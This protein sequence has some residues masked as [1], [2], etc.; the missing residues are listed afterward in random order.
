MASSSFFR[1]VSFDCGNHYTG[2]VV[3]DVRPG[4]FF[5]IVHMKLIVDTSKNKEELF[6]GIEAEIDPFV[7]YIQNKS[8]VILEQCLFPNWTLQRVQDKIKDHYTALGVRCKT[9]MPTQKSSGGLPGQKNIS[10]G[11]DKTRKQ[12]GI[13]GA[14]RLLDKLGVIQHI[15]YFGGLP[16]QHDVADALLAAYYLYEN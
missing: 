4:D 13:Q 15:D 8:L 9:M 5:E 16:R 10:S 7:K 12:A 3:A 1:V 6:A 14:K 11:D 2:V